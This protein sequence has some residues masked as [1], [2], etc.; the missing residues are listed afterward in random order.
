MLNNEN[1]INKNE[2]KIKICSKCLIKKELSEF[3]KDRTNITG[4]DSKCKLCKK[5]YYNNNKNEY[6]LRSLK[7][8]NNNPLYYEKYLKQWN[9]DNKEKLQD[10]RNNNKDKIQEYLNE[11]NKKNPEYAKQYKDNN[12]IRTRVRERERYKTDIE[13]RITKILRARLSF[14]IKFQKT[15]KSNKTLNLLGCTIPIFKIYLESLFK[16]EMNWDN[17]GSVWEIDHII[18]CTKFNLTIPEEQ[19]KC[20]HY[21]NMQPL[22]KTTIV[23]EQHGYTGEIGNRNKYNN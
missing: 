4:Y 18:A 8:K 11:W 12:K 13:W 2:I 5:E 1:E 20:F 6:K 23:A 7:F 17:Q 14:A 21:T 10:Y 19:A 15:F 22:F 16:P 9:E 3:G